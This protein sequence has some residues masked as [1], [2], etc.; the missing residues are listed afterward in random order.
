MDN[1]GYVVCHRSGAGAWTDD[2]ALAPGRRTAGRTRGRRERARV[3]GTVRALSPAAVPLLPLD[4]ARRCRRAGCPAVDL[5]GCAGRPT[6]VQ[7]QR[8]TTAVALPDRAQR[9]DLADSAAP[10]SRGGAV[11]AV[12]D[13]GARGVG[14]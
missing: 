3:Y 14:L 4:P 9:G 7:A 12:S 6:A 2:P 5:R 1:A 8:A 11:R 10:G 13:G